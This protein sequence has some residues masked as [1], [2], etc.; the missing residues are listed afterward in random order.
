MDAQNENDQ[1]KSNSKRKNKRRQKNIFPKL[2]ENENCLDSKKSA[3][4]MNRYSLSTQC[5]FQTNKFSSNQN[6]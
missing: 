6:T 3:S 4:D 1:R 5:S 2:K